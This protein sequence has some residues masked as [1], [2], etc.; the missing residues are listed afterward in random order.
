MFPN[1]VSRESTNLRPT[2][3]LT[4]VAILH[5]FHPTEQS[6]SHIKKSAKKFLSKNFRAEMSLQ[7]SVEDL[8]NPLVS[9]A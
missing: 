7:F 3:D 2:V 8:I 4:W 9:L 1:L 6:I 5:Y